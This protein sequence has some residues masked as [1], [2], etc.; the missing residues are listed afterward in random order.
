MRSIRLILVAASALALTVAAQAQERAGDAALGALSGAVVFGPV[1]LVAGAVVGFTAGPSI[2]RSWRHNRHYPRGARTKHPTRVASK[3]AVKP[4]GRATS[5]PP[6][7]GS[8]TPHAPA[9]GTGG[10]PVQSLE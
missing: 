2:S 8:V 6:E 10:P 7:A 3:S 4:R 9:P 1:G 5:A